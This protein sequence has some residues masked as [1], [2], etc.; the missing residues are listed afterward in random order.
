MILVRKEK[1]SYQRS[2]FW[3]WTK[4]AENLGLSGLKECVKTYKNWSEG[5]L[6]A[7]NYKYINGPTEGY[8]NKIKDYRDKHKNGSKY[9]NKAGFKESHPN[10]WRRGNKKILRNQ[11]FKYS[12]EGS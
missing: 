8:N 6:N 12:A 4:T 2:A 7:F 10:Y 1:Y 5:I 9:S 3:D 11:D